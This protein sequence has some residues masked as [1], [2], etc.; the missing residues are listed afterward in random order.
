MKENEFSSKEANYINIEIQAKF[1]KIEIAED[2]N[3]TT[4]KIS[5]HDR[6]QDAL[7]DLEENTKSFGEM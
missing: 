7:K 6:R 4:G 3:E 1:P 2:D 5:N